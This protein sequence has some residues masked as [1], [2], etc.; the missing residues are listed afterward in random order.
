M[1][2]QAGFAVLFFSIFRIMGHSE[3]FG[4]LMNFR[5]YWIRRRKK[6]KESD[7]MRIHYKEIKEIKESKERSLRKVNTRQRRNTYVQGKGGL[8]LAQRRSQR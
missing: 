2:D 5:R 8:V 1:Q 6:N 7:G 4:W 3:A